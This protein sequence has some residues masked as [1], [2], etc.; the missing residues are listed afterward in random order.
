MPPEARSVNGRARF[1]VLA[2]SHRQLETAQ[3]QAAGQVDPQQGR[4]RRGETPQGGACRAVDEDHRADGESS[5]HDVGEPQR[6]RG[7]RS[8]S[9]QGRQEE[10]PQR[11]V[12]VGRVQPVEGRA[13]AVP[14]MPGDN[15]I[16]V[17]VV[18]RRLQPHGDRP[19][20]DRRGIEG[21]EQGQPPIVEAIEH[22]I[23][24]GWPAI[25]LERCP[26]SPTDLPPLR[27]DRW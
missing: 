6:H 2:A 23:R 7:V 19:A 13:T 26:S 27:S 10:Q 5:L 21:Q 11:M 20:G 12:T 14:E 16:V 9:R 22:R 1:S 3:P 17:T 15:E 24:A 8:E 18:G 4:Q 25:P